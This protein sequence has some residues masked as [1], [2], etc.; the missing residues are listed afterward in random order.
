MIPIKMS[1]QIGIICIEILKPVRVAKVAK[2]MF[3]PKMFE[4]GLTVIESL[5]TELTQ[6]MTFHTR[7]VRIA[8]PPMPHKIL[9][10]VILSLPGKY[11]QFSDA[12]VAVIHLVLAPHVLVQLLEGFEEDLLRTY[13]TFMFQEHRV[14][15]LDLL[16]LEADFVLSVHGINV[17]L[18]ILVSL[19]RGGEDDLRH[20]LSADG[21]LVPL[22]QDPH[23][24][25]ADHAD[26]V[27]ALPHAPHL[28]GVHAHLAHGALLHLGHLALLPVSAPRSGRDHGVVGVGL[29]SVAHV[30]LAVHVSVTSLLP[31]LSALIL[32]VI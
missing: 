15:V 13:R 16:R 9:P 8:F 31:L 3:L 11:L 23:P 1:P 19:H 22:A 4:Q 28:D 21:A 14:A 17:I 26:H 29:A 18:D 12:Q 2:V 20:V 32:G 6:R 24:R 30:V 7:V 10:V 5:I 27:V 25:G